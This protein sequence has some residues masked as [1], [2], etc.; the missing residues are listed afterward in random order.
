MMI[1]LF[2]WLVAQTKNGRSTKVTYPL[3][4]ALTRPTYNFAVNESLLFNF[5]R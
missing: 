1:G 4:T 5:F 2:G 3:P